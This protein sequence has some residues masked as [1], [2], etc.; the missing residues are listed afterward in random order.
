MAVGDVNG[1]GVADI[2]TAP[3]PGIRTVIGIYDGS[4]GQL[5]GRF[6][7]FGNSYTGG[8]FVAVGNVDTDAAQEIVV[9]QQSGGLVRVF[10][11]DGTLVSGPLRQFRPYGADYAGGVTVAAGNYD[12]TGID[13]VI[14]GQF[15]GGTLVRV[16]RGESSTLARLANFAAYPGRSSGVYVAAGDLD[17]NGQAEVLT[18][19][20]RDFAQ[21]KTFYGTLAFGFEAYPASSKIGAR[22]AVLDLDGDGE[23]D[24]IAIAP[25]DKQH[26]NKVKLYD[27]SGVLIDE[28]VAFGSFGGGVYVG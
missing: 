21:V 7:P 5:L 9:G 17:G 14:V 3:G 28:W 18:T 13:E 20:A 16:F 22:V 12:G 10:N 26:I 19:P 27:P 24:R 8:A 23:I 4:S 2:V 25:S 6:R 1:D 15:S 11:G